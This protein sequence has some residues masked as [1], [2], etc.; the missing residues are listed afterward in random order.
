MELELALTPDTRWDA[1]LCAVAAAAHAAGFGALGIA[2]DRV[3]AG[4]VSTY[5][6]H[7]LRCHELLAL[8]ITDD[9]AATMNAAA[10]LASAA[11]TI[12]AEWLTTVFQ[13]G[14]DS[15]TR[16]LVRQCA[17]TLEEA[18]A[19]MAV[20][21]SPLGPL[22][23]IR[24]GLEVVAAAGAGAGL[25][26]DSWHFCF[27]SDTWGDLAAVPLE[28]IA[29]VQ[30]ADALAPQSDRLM[31]ETLNRRAMP[32]DGVLELDRFAGTLLDRGWQGLVSVEVLNREMRSM[33]I[34]DVARRAHEAARRYWC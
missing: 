3:D 31:S 14:L 1:D 33:P 29:Y 32:G 15:T 13:V 18:G 26:I 21:F 25:L 2:A 7:E 10:R 8:S 9:A 11:A 27:G 23:T 22:P 30:F 34:D 12:G 28:H 6:S 24:A 17:A 20:E 16:R 19:A 5:V 4:A